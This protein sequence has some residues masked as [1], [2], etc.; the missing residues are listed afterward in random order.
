MSEYEGLSDWDLQDVLLNP[1]GSVAP[2][3]PGEFTGGLTARELEA[4]QQ[5]ARVE[6]SRRGYSNDEIAAIEAWDDSPIRDRR[7]PSD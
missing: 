7:Y 5:A 3:S 6:F 1:L 2:L 4:I